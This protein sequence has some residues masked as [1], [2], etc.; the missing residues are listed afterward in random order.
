MSNYGSTNRDVLK[1]STDS[2]GDLIYDQHRLELLKYLVLDRFNKAISSDLLEADP[3]KV[4]VKVEP[5]KHTKIQEG[6]FRLIHAV[7]LIDSMV[8]RILFGP[9]MRNVTDPRNIL[10]TPCIVGWAP[11][12]GGWRVLVDTFRNGGFSID[13]TAWDWTVQ[14]WLVRLWEKFLIELHPNAPSWWITAVERRFTSLFYT[15]K[16]RFSDGV[17]IRQPTPGIMKSG[18]Y[19]T[20]VLNSVAQVILH[21]IAMIELGK[22]PYDFVPWCCGDDTIS[23]HMPFEEDYYQI[24]SKYCLV[25]EAQ[26]TIGFCEFIGF[27]FDKTGYYPAY[28]KKHLFQLRHLDQAVQ[29]EALISYQYNW[30]NHPPMLKFIQDMAFKI[31]PQLVIPLIILRD[32]ANN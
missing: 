30:Y 1:A 20:L 13:R 17:T 6:R 11:N 29:R 8:D 28:W 31:D 32:H 7:S 14:E 26:H 3:I 5:H 24:L 21:C 2:H 10:K 23:N 12:H 22:D 15:A 25:K 16:F 9:L 18:C 27:L 19:L 4:F